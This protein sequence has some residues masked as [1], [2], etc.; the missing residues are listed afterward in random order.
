MASLALISTTGNCK[1]HVCLT[2]CVYVCIY[3]CT[4]F[5]EC[6]VLFRFANCTTNSVGKKHNICKQCK[7]ITFLSKKNKQGV[8]VMNRENIKF[9]SLYRENDEV[10][11][12]PE[13]GDPFFFCFLCLFY[14]LGFALEIIKQNIKQKVKTCLLCPAH[15]I[16]TNVKIYTPFV[17][18]CVCLCLF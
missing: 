8:M 5:Q 7:N 11:F 1:R 3:V 4:C 2:L 17:C 6:L 16:S 14:F 13:S 18:V 9:H 15:L 12:S 10:V